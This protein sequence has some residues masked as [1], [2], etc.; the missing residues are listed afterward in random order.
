VECNG[1]TGHRVES[2][3]A[4]SILGSLAIGCARRRHGP[5]WFLRL[6]LHGPASF[7][8]RFE[9]AAEM[10]NLLKAHLLR[11]IGGQG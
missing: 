8:P 7:T 2:A 5:T 9:A 11:C 10:R 6:L 3:A 4:N 1:R